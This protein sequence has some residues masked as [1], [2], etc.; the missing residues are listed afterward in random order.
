MYYVF[1]KPSNGKR[2]Y[3]LFHSLTEAQGR[4]DDYEMDINFTNVMLLQDIENNPYKELYE[5]LY[6]DFVKP[7]NTIK[8]IL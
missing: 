3:D 7:K 4:I 2:E 1:Y 6:N 5:N 8:E